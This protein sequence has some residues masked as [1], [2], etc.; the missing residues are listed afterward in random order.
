[1]LTHL[2]A[3]LGLALMAGVWV[4]VQRWL[5]RWDPEA[6]GVEGSCHGCRGGCE[7]P[8]VCEEGPGSRVLKLPGPGRR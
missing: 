6:P 4:L 8:E 2:A 7:R 1:M 3:I 5:A